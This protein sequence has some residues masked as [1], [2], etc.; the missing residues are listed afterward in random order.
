MLPCFVRTL[1]D[2]VAP[3]DNDPNCISYVYTSSLEYIFDSNSGL[4]GPMLICKRGNPI[5]KFDF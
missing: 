4:V 1:P 5:K 3:G 2:T